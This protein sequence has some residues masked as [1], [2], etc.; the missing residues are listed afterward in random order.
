[1]W[2]L[3]GGMR[4]LEV[5]GDGVLFNDMNACNDYKGGDDAAQNLS[6]PTLSIIGERDMMTPM[7]QCRKLAAQI[8]NVCEVVIPGAGHIMMDE[9]PDETLDALRDFLLGS[10]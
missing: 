8:D 6:C 5:A 1:M 9:A 10:T 7:K 4:L 3:K 2:M